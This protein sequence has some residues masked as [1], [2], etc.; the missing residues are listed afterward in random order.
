MA[1]PQRGHHRQRHHD[2]AD[3]GELDDEDFPG[4]ESAAR[5]VRSR[6]GPHMGGRSL[7]AFGRAGEF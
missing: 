5:L 2:V 3:R 6:P 1:R 7:D 4:H